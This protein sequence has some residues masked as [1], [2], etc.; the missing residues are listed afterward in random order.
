MVLAFRSIAPVQSLV[1]ALI[2]GC[3][4]CLGPASLNAAVVS[5]TF[6]R[7]DVFH[8]SPKL[9]HGDIPKSRIPRLPKSSAS[10]FVTEPVVIDFADSLSVPST[11]AETLN[12]FA[13][14]HKHSFVVERPL[15]DNN[16]QSTNP[17]ASVA[18][19]ESRSGV[20]KR[21]SRA[22]MRA[23]KAAKG[24][25]PPGNNEIHGLVSSLRRNSD[26]VPHKQARFVSTTTT[27]SG[28]SKPPSHT[29]V[30]TSG[31]SR[32]STSFTSTK[33]PGQNV[34]SFKDDS[35]P[36]DNQQQST[37]PP[38]EISTTTRRASATTSNHFARQRMTH[39]AS[40]SPTTSFKT[41]AALASTTS[42]SS[43]VS[44]RAKTKSTEIPSRSDGSRTHEHNRFSDHAGTSPPAG[45]PTTSSATQTSTLDVGDRGDAEEHSADRFPSR[46]NPP[47]DTP[48][49]D[50]GGSSTSRPSSTSRTRGAYV[51]HE[52][53]KEDIR[54]TESPMSS[55]ATRNVGTDSDVLKQ[56][57]EPPSPPKSS[58]G[59][60]D[61]RVIGLP[62][63][64]SGPTSAAPPAEASSKQTAGVS[65]TSAS[66]PSS[67]ITGKQ[68]TVQAGTSAATT[69]ADVSTAPVSEN[70]QTAPKTV[71][72]ET[73]S[74]ST[75]QSPSVASSENA[76]FIP[77][78]DGGSSEAPST[79]TVATEPG[80]TE[81]KNVPTTEVAPTQ[82]QT[83]LPATT[84][85]A[86]TEQN[87]FVPFSAVSPSPS[88]NLEQS[89]QSNSQTTGIFGPPQNSPAPPSPYPSPMS[90]G[91]TV[92]PETDADTVIVND[93]SSPAPSPSVQPSVSPASNPVTPVKPE[94]T[95]V[96]PKPTPSGS[97]EKKNGDKQDDSSSETKSKFGD[98]KSGRGFAAGMGI[99][100]VLLILLLAICLF[101]AVYRGRQYSYYNSG[102]GSRSPPKSARPRNVGP[103]QA[104]AARPRTDP[105]D[106]TESK[107][108]GRG[109]YDDI[110]AELGGVGT[111]TTLD[112]AETLA[113]PHV[114]A[115]MQGP[116]ISSRP[117]HEHDPVPPTLNTVSGL[118]SSEISMPYDEDLPDE[119]AMHPVARVPR[120]T[121]RY[122]D[123]TIDDSESH[124]IG[125][126][127]FPSRPVRSPPPPPSFESGNGQ[128]TNHEDAPSVLP[129]TPPFEPTRNVG[130]NAARENSFVPLRQQ[131]AQPPDIDARHD[132]HDPANVY[133]GIT[134]APSNNRVMT[135]SFEDNRSISPPVP[136]QPESSGNQRSVLEAVA[137]FESRDRGSQTHRTCEPNIPL[138]RNAQVAQNIQPSTTS[139]L[140]DSDS[141]ISRSGISRIPQGLVQPDQVTGG[142]QQFPKSLPKVAEDSSTENIDSKRTLAYR[143][144]PAEDAVSD[145]NKDGMPYNVHPTTT[146]R[147][148]EKGVVHYLMPSSDGKAVESNGY[149]VYPSAKKAP[150]L[151]FGDTDDEG[152]TEGSSSDATVEGIHDKTRS[153]TAHGQQGV[154][155]EASSVTATA[156]KADKTNILN[157]S[158]VYSRTADFG[159]DDGT[160]DH[161]IPRPD[162]GPVISYLQRSKAYRG[163]EESECSPHI[164]PPTGMSYGVVKATA[165]ELRLRR[166]PFVGKKAA[167]ISDEDLD[168]DNN[169]SAVRALQ[170]T[171]NHV[172]SASSPIAW[173]RDSDGSQ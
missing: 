111:G 107:Y 32:S 1:A 39:K 155:S 116:N 89:S 119:D 115:H 38:V 127:S 62:I 162:S 114:G 66:P 88:A 145:G 79:S 135:D 10:R 72:A 124:G 137:L 51:S 86:K 140:H 54:S 95:A 90:T 97:D 117:I 109:E 23:D 22:A 42:T 40:I 47:K 144:S 12:E 171:G 108:R 11:V 138:A 24:S 133:H 70:M 168:N 14:E 134:V 157:L 163:V 84:E 142:T 149:Y 154:G 57:G 56:V 73:T 83:S 21:T 78:D 130:S 6:H 13:E 61:G 9:D 125:V 37:N 167:R 28:T 8:G 166:E 43:A 129:T 121:Y 105:S 169:G 30:F 91:P 76:I 49:L 128:R 161:Y 35:T 153:V 60:S 64:V 18:I 113:R 33:N 141:K 118:D 81:P 112:D 45:A 20:R 44:I 65:T 170:E 101:F 55:S 106:E 3:F 25:E 87:I 131:F 5:P 136:S 123:D 120:S 80:A 92:K 19:P 74:S 96:S 82:T 50:G 102:S 48:H 85:M 15:E 36:R 2:V 132:F 99:L 150:W 156:S 27:P 159:V 172:S 53:V 31:T 110:D 77:L 41:S 26:S 29:T 59:T 143:N 122:D 126:H 63:G 148:S 67:T 34:G 16:L 4:L 160:D 75:G 71:A 100:G 98:R 46:R 173:L 17:K 139:I 52:F 7:Y 58:P 69:P 151:Y 152:M 94:T 165:E 68:T 147:E 146:S 104:A 158:K 103:S 93:D 164:S